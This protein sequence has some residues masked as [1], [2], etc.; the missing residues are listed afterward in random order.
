MILSV[1]HTI[2]QQVRRAGALVNVNWKGRGWKQSRLNFR[3]Y[4]G[5]CLGVT[6]QNREEKISRG[7]CYPG[8]D[9]KGP[10]SDQKSEAL[11]PKPTGSFTPAGKDLVK[12][13]FLFCGIRWFIILYTKA[14]LSQMNLV[15]TFCKFNF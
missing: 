4:P 1:H 13:F 7:S 10:P 12:K 9:S 11:P 8:R 15:H 3:Y 6:E 2:G 5:I 14:R